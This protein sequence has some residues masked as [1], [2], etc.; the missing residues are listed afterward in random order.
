MI[1][2][3]NG[4]ALQ[5][6][7][8]EPG[9]TERDPSLL[10]IHGAGGSGEIWEGQGPFFKGRHSIFR[11]DL[12]G[13]GGSD[14]RGEDRIHAYAE[15]ARMSS[16]KLFEQRPFVLVGHSM[17]GAIV[18]EL[19]L[20]P[21]A[22]LKG[23][24][25]V[26]SGA[27]LA[28]TRAIFQ[29]LSEDPEAFFQSIDQFAFSSAAPKALRERF[30]RVTRKCPPS[31]IFND[32]KACDHFDIRNRLHEIKLPTLVLCGDEDQLTPAKYSRYL[33]EN[34]VASLLVLIPQAG[35]MVMAEQPDLFNR[36]IAS[37]LENL[38]I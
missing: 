29:M 35:H 28:V 9:G 13:H 34:I 38:G 37:F 6:L 18:L 30:T 10:F 17:G 1:L 11:L 19:A 24:V 26:G 15:W 36:A 20:K 27:K 32:F 8:P 22:G 25:V 21:P 4:A 33:H 12:P 16:E 2:D 31:V 7:E 5:V 3:V 23:I 14:S